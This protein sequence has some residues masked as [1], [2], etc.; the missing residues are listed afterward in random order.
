MLPFLYEYPI[1]M[2]ICQNFA[3]ILRKWK[4]KNIC[5]LVS[6]LLFLI[7]EICETEQRIHYST[8]YFIRLLCQLTQSEGR[9]TMMP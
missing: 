9:F 6:Q 1:L 7:P 4:I 2:N 3:T 8:R 5:N